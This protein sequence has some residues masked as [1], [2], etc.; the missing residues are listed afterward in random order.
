VSPNPILIIIVILGALEL[1]RRWRERG[2][3]EEYY[4]LEVWQ[5]VTVAVVYL[6][7]IAVLAL[8]VSATHVE[9]TF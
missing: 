4:R 8:A 7:L 1:W 3:N 6:G 2:E 9:R 5:R